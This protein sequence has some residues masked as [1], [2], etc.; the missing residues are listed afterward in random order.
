MMFEDAVS[1][2]NWREGKSLRWTSDIL[3]QIRTADSHM[4]RLYENLTWVQL[5]AR[6]ILNAHVF[7]SVVASCAHH[8]C[9]SIQLLSLSTFTQ[10]DCSEGSK[11]GSRETAQSY[12]VLFEATQP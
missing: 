4:R 5:R 2:E 8:L 6:G 12:S 9:G 1:K 10:H 11:R 7:L 3:M